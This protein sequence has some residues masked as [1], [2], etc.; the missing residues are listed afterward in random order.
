M[1]DI[2]KT[3][4][5][6]GYDPLMLTHGSAKKVWAVCNGCGIGRW[7]RMYGYRDLCLTCSM[8]QP[9]IRESIRLKANDRLLDLSAWDGMS[10]DFVKYL[11]DYKDG[12]LYW[13]V[14]INGQFQKG[15][16]AGYLRKDGYRNIQIDGKSYLAHRLIFLYHHGYLPEFLDHIDGNPRNNNISNLRE[17]TSQENS[18][19]QKKHKS[20]NGKSTSSDFKGVS[21]RELAKKWQAYIMINGKYKHLGMFKSD[22]DAAL[23]SDRAAI[24]RDGK[25]ARTNAMLFPEIFNHLPTKH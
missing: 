23:A 4:S 21:W 5:L 9:K 12:N 8:R 19:N 22:I 1:I 3:I 6:R 10:Q 15:D 18:R 2:E 14:I 13:S 20:R 16:L 24:K 7:V 11:F 25:F 17:A